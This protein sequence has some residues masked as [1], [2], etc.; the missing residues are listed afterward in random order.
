MLS[1]KCEDCLFQV[2]IFTIYGFFNNI[3]AITNYP[4]GHYDIYNKRIAKK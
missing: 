3:Y 4:L 1:V 2:S